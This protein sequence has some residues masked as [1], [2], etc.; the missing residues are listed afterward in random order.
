M[1]LYTFRRASEEKKLGSTVLQQQCH[2]FGLITLFGPRGELEHKLLVNCAE[3]GVKEEKRNIVKPRNAP[4][5]QN[6]LLQVL[7][8]FYSGL[9]KDTKKKKK[10][11]AE[12]N[13]SSS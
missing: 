5:S 9:N 13:L 3:D 4:C 6:E 12:A 7:T 8:H 2:L 10:S 1:V 11:K